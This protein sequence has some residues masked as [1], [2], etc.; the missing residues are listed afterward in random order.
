MS[1]GIQLLE[2][3]FLVFPGVREDRIARDGAS[4]A[5]ELLEFGDVF[6]AEQPHM[7]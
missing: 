2:G 3:D 4:V 6:G 1:P 5:D 7:S